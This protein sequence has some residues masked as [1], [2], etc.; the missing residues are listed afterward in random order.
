MYSGVDFSSGVSHESGPFEET[1]LWGRR[2]DHEKT[3]GSPTLTVTLEGLKRKKGPTLTF[4][5]HSDRMR[6][7]APQIRKQ[8][9]VMVQLKEVVQII[10]GV[11]EV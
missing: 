5:S 11:K 8:R 4:C 7:D 9:E 3:T 10:I 1:T 2:P 6:R